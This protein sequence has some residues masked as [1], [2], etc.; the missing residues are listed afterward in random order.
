M[1]C[2]AWKIY[3]TLWHAHLPS[4]WAKRSSPTEPHSF[5]CFPAATQPLTGASILTLAPRWRHPVS[6]IVLPGRHFSA[7]EKRLFGRP[8][9][10]SNLPRKREDVRACDAE[11]VCVGKASGSSAGS[12][13]RKTGRALLVF[14]RPLG[15][16]NRENKPI[17][18]W[19]FFRDRAGIERWGKRGVVTF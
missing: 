17:A 8:A 10:L 4:P 18:E 11:A 5:S 15:R 7:G 14:T 1:F 13:G 19:F 16:L 6:P 9:R 2:F 12:T 3:I